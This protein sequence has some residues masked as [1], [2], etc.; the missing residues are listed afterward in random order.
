MSTQQTMAERLSYH[1]LDLLGL[2]W[3]E[4]GELEDSLGIVS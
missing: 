1:D 3:K 2:M 4:D